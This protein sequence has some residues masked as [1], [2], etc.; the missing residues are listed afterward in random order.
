M[1]LVVAD[2]G[3]ARFACAEA[4]D[5]D[6][7]GGRSR[8]IAIRS[9]FPGSRPRPGA[10]R[11]GAPPSWR[12]RRSPPPRTSRP[13]RCGSRRPSLGPGRLPATLPSQFVSR[14]QSHPEVPS[15]S[16]NAAPSIERGGHARGHGHAPERPCLLP[17]STARCCPTG[18]TVIRARRRRRPRRY[19][20]PCAMPIIASNCFSV[21]SV[22]TSGNWPL[23][24]AWTASFRAPR[25]HLSS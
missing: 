9:S 15:S 21:R 7:A 6:R 18:R 22:M 19:P 5:P 24:A 10:G 8:D 20:E 23:R 13:A 16:E 11:P 25:I 17:T 2:A 12:V 3:T 4:D 14:W 1:R